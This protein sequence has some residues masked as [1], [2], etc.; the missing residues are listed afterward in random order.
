LAPLAIWLSAALLAGPIL[1]VEREHPL[2]SLEAF[3]IVGIAHFSHADV[4]PGK[5][6]AAELRQVDKCYR[7]DKWDHLAEGPCTFFSDELD[8]NGFWGKPA[9]THAWIGAI[10]AHPVAYL[11]HRIANLNALLRWRGPLSSED[12]FLESEITD[13]RYENHPSWLFRAY[14]NVCQA[15]VENPLFRPY[16]WLILSLGAVAASFFA[17]ASEGR[18]LALAVSVSGVIYLLTYFIVG[19]GA[20]FRYA[21]WTIVGALIA[22]AA[23]LAC[24]WRSPRG[25][26]VALA[27]TGAVLIAAIALS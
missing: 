10:A 12:S 1:H 17:E 11:T 24:R 4:I 26:S 6:S 21:Y 8:D 15:L 7:P 25:A 5:W 22:A 18:R 20:D 19:V 2:A 23:L 14:E 27:G 16:F 3:D 13:P 9:L